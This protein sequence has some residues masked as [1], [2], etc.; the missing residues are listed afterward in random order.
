LEKLALIDLVNCG[1][2][3]ITTALLRIEDK[4]TAV[5]ADTDMG[6]ENNEDV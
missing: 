4:C 5:S 1:S 2:N 6:E 3:V